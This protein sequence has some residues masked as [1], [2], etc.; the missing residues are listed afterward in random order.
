MKEIKLAPGERSAVRLTLTLAERYG[1]GN[2]IAWLKTGWTERLME[3]GLS[4]HS[5]IEAGRVSAYLVSYLELIR[6][7]DWRER[8]VPGEA[9]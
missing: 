2:L 6:P 4:E 3:D 1:Y 9:E 5:I 8:A 7:P